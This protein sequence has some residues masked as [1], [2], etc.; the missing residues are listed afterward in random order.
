MSDYGPSQP[1]TREEFV[2]AWAAVTGMARQLD[3]LLRAHRILAT[4]LKSL[5]QQ[6]GVLSQQVDALTPGKVNA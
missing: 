1:V 3:D 5:D 4:R 2:R 6:V